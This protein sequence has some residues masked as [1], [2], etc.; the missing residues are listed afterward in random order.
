VGK[1]FI[2]SDVKGLHETT[3]DAGILFPYQDADALA[4]EIQ[5][6]M[7][8]TDYYKMIADRCMKRAEEF[9]ISKTA[10]G[11]RRVYEELKKK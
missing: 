11:Y 7:T 5:H 1:P 8:D 10:D 9:D 3:I 6:L 4:K 2:A